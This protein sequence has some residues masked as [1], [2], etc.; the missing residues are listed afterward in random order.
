MLAQGNMRG[1]PALA[2]G[3]NSDIAVWETTSDKGTEG[4]LR[5]LG[6]DGP[7]VSIGLNVELPAAA[8]S[9]DGLFIAY[10]SKVKDKRSVW[11]IKADHK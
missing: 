11:L 4:K 8:M 9:K 7:P 2:A 3:T 6:D 10:V 1:T 5:T